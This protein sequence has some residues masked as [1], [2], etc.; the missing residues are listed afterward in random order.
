MRGLAAEEASRSPSEALAIP[1]KEGAA[2]PGG[3]DGEEGQIVQGNSRVT[4]PGGVQ[5]PWRWSTERRG[6]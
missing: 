4:A 1:G 5:E 6:Q 3:A 2:K